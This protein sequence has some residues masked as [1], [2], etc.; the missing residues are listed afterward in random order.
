MR[1][2]IE[3]RSLN[4][5]IDA[6]IKAVPLRTSVPML[7][8]VYLKAE[9]GGLLL[10]CT[11]MNLQKEILLPATVSETGEALLPNKLFSDVV[12]RLPDDLCT[13]GQSENRLEIRC[14]KVETDIQCLEYDQY[15][16]L[17]FGDTP[18]C[19]TMDKDVLK[20]MIERTVFAT[21]QDDSRPILAGA[22][23][24]TGEVV[25][26][27]ATD[28]FQFAM[29]RVHMEKPLPAQEYVVLHEYVHF[30]H[31]NHGPA[32]HAE[33]AR[34]MPDDKARRRLLR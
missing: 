24:E 33:M 4:D 7:E 11:D 25:R 6:V 22:L 10:R 28:S 14:G 21:A 5:G 32:F 15:P 17:S 13:I 20:R 12:R 30:L 34:L 23:L 19:L 27:V 3:A 26:L 8:G 1:F 18:F 2:T 9:E 29:Q 16:R 31:P